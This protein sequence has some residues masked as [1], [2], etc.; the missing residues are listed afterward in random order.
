MGKEKISRKRIEPFGSLLCFQLCFQNACNHP[1]WRQHQ[2]W[3]NMRV[4]RVPRDE[5]TELGN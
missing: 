5:R 2:K 4:C 3:Q 1:Q